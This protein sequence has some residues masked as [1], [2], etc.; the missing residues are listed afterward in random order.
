MGHATLLALA[1]I[2]VTQSVSEI[3]GTEAG[4]V[5]GATVALRGKCVQLAFELL[6]HAVVLVPLVVEHVFR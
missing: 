2:V 5:L 1:A 3:A 6:L 4:V